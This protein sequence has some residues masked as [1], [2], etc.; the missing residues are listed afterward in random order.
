MSTEKTQALIVN[1]AIELFNEYGTT[2]VATNRI[3]DVCGIS[4][5]N[6]HYHFNNKES[7]IQFIFGQMVQKIDQ[8]WRDDYLDPTAKHMAEMFYRQLVLTW[9]Y[10][11]F[12]RELTPLL[13]NDPYLKD[14][15]SEFRKRRFIEVEK[16]FK[17]LIK[18]GLLINMDSVSFSSIMTVSWIVCDYWISYIDV[19][20]KKINRDTIAEGYVILVQLLE[21]YLTE[22]AH[23]DV[24]ESFKILSASSA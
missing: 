23:K 6:L 3:A 10:R 7:I 5:G 12:Y 14:R 20:G 22:E 16:F 19:E 17:T 21:P 18:K 9:D 13:Q 8:D 2:K 11:F 1:T 4:K 15:F 24:Q